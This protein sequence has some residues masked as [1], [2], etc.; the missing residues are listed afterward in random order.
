[1]ITV[2]EF[3]TRIRAGE[4]DYLWE[5][6]ILGGSA[7]HVDNHLIGHATQTLAA[8]YGVPTGDLY[9]RIVGSAKLGSRNH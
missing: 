7:K 2:D 8:K 1:M 3:R 5:E 9:L 6:V 4:L